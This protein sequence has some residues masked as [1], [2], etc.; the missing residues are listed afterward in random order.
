MQKN[1]FA[2]IG[3]LISLLVLA[4]IMIMV[5]NRL[6][7]KKLLDQLSPLYSEESEV[8]E[9]ENISN[10]TVQIKGTAKK[11]K[12][13]PN[14]YDPRIHTVVDDPRSLDEETIKALCRSETNITSEAANLK[15]IGGPAAR[16]GINTAYNICLAK[17]GI[18]E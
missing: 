1:G 15:D 13:S 10:I 17:F 12:I 16:A 5:I 6:T 2:L 7:D 8:G 18:V 4:A 14:D 9:N 11:E 3:M